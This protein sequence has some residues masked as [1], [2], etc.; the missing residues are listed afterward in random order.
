MTRL[1]RGVPAIVALAGL[2][3]F[4]VGP[5][6]AKVKRHHATP[7]HHVVRSPYN[8]PNYVSRG[9][10]RNPGGDNLYYTDTKAPA[11]FFGPTLLGPAYFQRW[12]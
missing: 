4:A 5:A 12:W 10:D 2:A 6:D 11:Y 3:A 7:K 8:F 9:V 1:P